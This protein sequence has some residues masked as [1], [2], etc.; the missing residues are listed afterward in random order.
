MNVD[1]QSIGL[2]RSL[3]AHLLRCNSWARAAWPQGETLLP[4]PA[5]RP[6]MGRAHLPAAPAQPLPAQEERVG[7]RAKIP[8]VAVK[9][10]PLCSYHIWKHANLASTIIAN[11]AAPGIEFSLRG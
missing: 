8:W 4:Q 1:G 9:G 5:P 2:A 11:T 10:K 7:E 3:A 6:R